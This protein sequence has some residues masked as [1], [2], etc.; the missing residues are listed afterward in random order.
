MLDPIRLWVLIM[1]DGKDVRPMIH[2]LFLPTIDLHRRDVVLPADPL[3][4]PVAADEDPVVQGIPLSLSDLCHTP[5]NS[6]KVI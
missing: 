5:H 2:Q 6:N 3:V 1:L 4:A